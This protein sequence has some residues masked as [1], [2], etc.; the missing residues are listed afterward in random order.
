MLRDNHHGMLSLL[1]S[2]DSQG[3][4]QVEEERLDDSIANLHM[5]SPDVEHSLPRQGQ[6][7]SLTVRRVLRVRK[8]LLRL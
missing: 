3:A 2:A 8:S 7:V 4:R 6:R 1:L 5:L